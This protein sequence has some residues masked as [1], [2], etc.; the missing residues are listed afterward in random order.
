M[1]H[2]CGRSVLLMD[3]LDI[4]LLIYTFS[5]VELYQLD[6]H[7]P[8]YISLD[9]QDFVGCK[10]LHTEHIGSIVVLLWGTLLGNQLVEY[11]FLH[12]EQYQLDS[13]TQVY[14]SKDMLD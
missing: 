13:H 2:T 14:I 12:V 6:R 11:T 3:T 7:I 8:A 10:W 1:E 4:R 9:I 5:R